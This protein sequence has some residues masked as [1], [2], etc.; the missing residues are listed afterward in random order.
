MHDNLVVQPV[1]VVKAQTDRNQG[2][3]PETTSSKR[4]TFDKGDFETVNLSQG[5][6][7][8]SRTDS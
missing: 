4:Q 1:V 6:P 2:T 7:E 8:T 3:I 5:D